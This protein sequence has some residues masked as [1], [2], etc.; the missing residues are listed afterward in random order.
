MIARTQLKTRMGFSADEKA[1]QTLRLLKA[2]FKEI[3]PE[4]LSI[5]VILRRSL[6]LYFNQIGLLDEEGLK[7]EWSNL[8]SFVE[9]RA[10]G[11]Q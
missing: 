2:K 7:Q 3:S 4:Y 6:A 8:R 11:R 10:E 5:S 9:A 1:K